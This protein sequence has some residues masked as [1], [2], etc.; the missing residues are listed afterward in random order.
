MKRIKLT[1]KKI[2]LHSIIS[3]FIKMRLYSII[4][5]VIIVL[6]FLIKQCTTP[7]SSSHHWRAGGDTLNVAIELSPTSVKTDGDT[8]S[9]FHYEI[10]Q[11]YAKEKNINIQFSGFS[12]LKSAIEGLKKGQYDLI[13]SDIPTTAKLKTDYIFTNPI[14]IDRRVLVRQKTGEAKQFSQISLAGET[15]YVAAGGPD[16]DRLAGLSREIGDTIHIIEDP[17]YGPEQLAILVALGEIKQ[18]VV[19]EEIA[20]HIAEDYPNLDIN[21]AVSFNQFQSWMTTPKHQELCDSINSWLAKYNKTKRFKN[22]KSK[23]LRSTK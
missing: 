14:Y 13:V 19:G 6:C 17:E 12:N 16:A 4:L 21:N 23:Y 8:L 3:A 22:L 11:D 1:K 7:S 10:L 20:R 18:A 5:A 15:I 2:C 9:G